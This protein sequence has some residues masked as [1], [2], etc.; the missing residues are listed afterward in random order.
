[1]RSYKMHHHEHVEFRVL[2]E[3]SYCNCRDVLIWWLGYTV[4]PQCCYSVH[5][6]RR[7]PIMQRTSLYVH[8]METVLLKP[9]TSY[10]VITWMPTC[11]NAVTQH[12]SVTLPWECCTLLNCICYFL[13]D[14]SSNRL[15]LG[16][17]ASIPSLWHLCTNAT[18]L[19]SLHLYG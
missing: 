8:M 14:L 10:N 4:D 5:N 13:H 11:T 1:M 7:S 17:Y 16:K 3:V 2:V 12:C 18:S 9:V 6:H 19:E 15:C